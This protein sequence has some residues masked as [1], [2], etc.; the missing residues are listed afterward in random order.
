MGQLG[1]G[2]KQPMWHQKE[3]WVTQVG[4]WG[5]NRQESHS[6]Q[7]IR[8]A[9]PKEQSISSVFTASLAGKSR[10]PS[11]FWTSSQV[12]KMFCFFVLFPPCPLPRCYKKILKL[13]PQSNLKGIPAEFFPNSFMARTKKWEEN[14]APTSTGIYI[15]TYIILVLPNFKIPLPTF[16]SASLP[17]CSGNLQV[18][19]CLDM[20]AKSTTTL[21]LDNSEPLSRGRGVGVGIG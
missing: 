16:F 17:A 15:L 12:S 11:L 20:L 19:K 14:S 21:S 4:S 13:Q 5:R 10:R 2:T 8:R 6:N 18:Q 7:L 1:L 3:K 9:A